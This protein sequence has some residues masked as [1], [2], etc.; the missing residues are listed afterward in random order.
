MRMAPC[1]SSG[2]AF[3]C[4]YD[5]AAGHGQA[6]AAQCWNS[7]WYVSG[8]LFP[9]PACTVTNPETCDAGDAADGG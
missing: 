5:C 8:A 6:S 7:K 3:G 4:S 2:G 9:C 1:D